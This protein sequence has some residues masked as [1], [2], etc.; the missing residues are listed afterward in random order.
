MN[1]MEWMLGISS[2]HAQVLMIPAQY[3]AMMAAHH[4]HLS[5]I[6][7]TTS[8]QAYRMKKALELLE[9]TDYSGMLTDESARVNHAMDLLRDKPPA[10]VLDGGYIYPHSGDEHD[11]MGKRLRE[12]A[13]HLSQADTAVK[14]MVEKQCEHLYSCEPGKPTVCTKCG[15]VFDP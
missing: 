7:S 11:L 15:A 3:A 1:L 13:E 5:Q 6:Q 9:G 8:Y 2:S 12:I 10:L 14:S 4:V